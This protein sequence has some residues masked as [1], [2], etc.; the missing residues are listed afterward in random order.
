MENLPADDFHWQ[1]YILEPFVSRFDYK[2]YILK[3]F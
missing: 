2:L 1:F 3:I